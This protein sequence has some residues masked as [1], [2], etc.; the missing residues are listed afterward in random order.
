V[1]I[2]IAIEGYSWEYGRTHTG[3]GQLFTS[4]TLRDHPT[5]HYEGKSRSKHPLIVVHRLRGAHDP[6][7]LAK[8]QQISSGERDKCDIDNSAE[9][10]NGNHHGGDSKWRLEL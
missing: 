7:T 9:T 6:P 5:L 8:Q 10:E 3:R 4:G 2:S 1:E